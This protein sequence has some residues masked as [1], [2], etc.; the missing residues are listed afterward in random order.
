MTSADAVLVVG[1]GISGLACAHALRSAGVP[2]RVVERG[3]VP[4]GRMA[5][6]RLEG[7]PVDLG[8]AFFT[9]DLATGFGAVVQ[10]WLDRGVA[11]PWTDTFSVS[12]DGRP[13]TAK[14]G[15]MRY[16]APAGL[17]ALTTEL[18]EGLDIEFEHAVDAVSTDG[19]A[20]GQHG[21]TGA[22]GAGITVLAMPD[23]Q[24]RRL[25]P[26][27]SAP[28]AALDGGVGWAPTIAVALGWD[29]QVW[30]RDIHGVFVNGSPT[31]TFVADDG[32][33]RGDGAPVLVAHSTPELAGRHLSEPDAAIGPITEAVRALLD[34]G[35]APSWSYAH[36]WTFARTLAGHPEPYLLH[37][38]I[39]ICGDGWG[40]TSSVGTA[41]ASGDALG[42]AIAATRG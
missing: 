6:R 37:D 8:A 35:V 38:G 12:D 33:R 34:I 4:G 15:P 17:R 5:S 13:L 29:R 18:A 3:R 2:V 41:W 32:D 11:R 10:G 39:G 14:S 42:Q 9:A 31:L 7:R 24:A 40:G 16:A 36:R 25:L 27:G 19:A 22:L 1:A 21:Q 26:P 23:P 30:P 20:G 28:A